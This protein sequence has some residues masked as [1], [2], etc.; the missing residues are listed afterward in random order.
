VVTALC[1][2]AGGWLGIPRFFSQK[3]R[4]SLS[5]RSQA[6]LLPSSAISNGQAGWW[7]RPVGCQGCCGELL[8]L[9]GTCLSHDCRD[10]CKLRVESR[11][12]VQ[13]CTNR[14]YTESKKCS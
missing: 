14:Q 1:V 9:G 12:E 4:S 7:W 3:L 5:W 10:W 2:A 11:P 6:E 8:S 13:C